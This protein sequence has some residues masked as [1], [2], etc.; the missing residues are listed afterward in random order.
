MSFVRLRYI[1]SSEI[2]VKHFSRSQTK[3]ANLIPN[4]AY[5]EGNSS[6]VSWLTRGINLAGSAFPLEIGRSKIN[7]ACLRIWR[8][9]VLMEEAGA[10]FSATACDRFQLLF[11][12][13]GSAFG[14][15]PAE[16]PQH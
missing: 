12:R 16:H 4:E 6:N 2:L 9:R 14:P 3:V 10:L 1:P 5:P 11:I 15:D 7:T 13:R 8:A